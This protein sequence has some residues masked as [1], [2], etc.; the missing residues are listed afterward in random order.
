M[1]RKAFL[2]WVNGD[3]H[4][5]YQ[6]RHGALWP[7][8]RDA[9]EEHG[10]RSYSIF[11]HPEL[12]LLFAYVEFESLEQWEAIAATPVCRRWWAFMRDI[13]PANPDDSPVSTDLKEVFHL[14]VGPKQPSRREACLSH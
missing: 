14:Q 3:A 11:L 6:R 2:M 1:I 5:E 8:M 13:M 4:D 12:N 7:E 9:L 10:V